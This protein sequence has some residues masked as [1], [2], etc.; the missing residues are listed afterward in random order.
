L[1]YFIYH[2]GEVMQIFKVIGNTIAAVGQ[3]VQDTAELASMVVSDQGLKTTSRASFGIV[4]TALIESEQIAI[5]ESE[6]N[7]AKFKEDH[8]KKLGRPKGSKNK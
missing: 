1:S 6:Y 7:L 8:A 5:A 2:Q 4:N 3:T